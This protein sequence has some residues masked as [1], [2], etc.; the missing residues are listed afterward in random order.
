MKE[1]WNERF[2]KKEYAYGIEPNAFLKS[3]LLKLKPGKILFPAE[4]EGTNSV[5]AA[6]LGWNV[7]AFDNGREGRRNGSSLQ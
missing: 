6:T 3:E 7:V 4:G 1:F 5:F 2:S